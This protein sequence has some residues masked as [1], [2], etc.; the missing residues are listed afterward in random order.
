VASA[1]A[2]EPPAAIGERAG[3]T[4]E[5]VS[6]LRDV[7]QVLSGV[8]TAAGASALVLAVWLGWSLAR[9]RRRAVWSAIQAGGWTILVLVG[10]LAV[11]ALIGFDAA[12]S[13]LHG[14]F[15]APGTW[16]FP[17]DSLLIQLFPERFW[18]AMGTILFA[19]VLAG[20]SGMALLGHRVRSR[21][22]G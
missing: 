20:G 15:F 10:A 21:A 22:V 3:F 16:Q 19:L 14:V 18:M 8:R 1:R 7:R 2:D 5:E 11:F 12:F 6:H 13:A 4:P 9:A 17:A